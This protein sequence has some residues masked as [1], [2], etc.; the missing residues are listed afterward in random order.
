[1]DLQETSPEQN[2]PKE[3]PRTGKVKFHNMSLKYD[4]NGP[5]TLKNLSFEIESGWKV[6][7]VG[8]F[9]IRGGEMIKRK[10]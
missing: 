4:K 8:R 3:W 9:S 2:A 1:M 5:A 10:H 6:G 7:V